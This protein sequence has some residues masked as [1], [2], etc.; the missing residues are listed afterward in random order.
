MS[1][2]DIDKL[3]LYLD[4]GYN[5]LLEGDAGVGKTQVITEI[6]DEKFANWKYFSAATMDPWVDFIGVPKEMKDTDGN[7]Y[8][9]LVRPKDFA[10]DNVEAIF[11]DE[12]NRSPKAVRNAIMELIQFKRINGK[13]FKNL[14]VVWAAVN[15]S[16]SGDY[17]V[18]ELCRAQKDRFQIQIKIPYRPDKEYFS[19]HHSQQGERICDWWHGIG[20]KMQKTISPRRLEYALDVLNKGGDL[21]D[22]LGADANCKELKKVLKNGNQWEEI[23][24]ILKNRDVEAAKKIMKNDV[25]VQ[26]CGEDILKK[27]LFLHFFGRYMP[28]EY[29][30][31]YCN[32]DTSNR[33][34]KITDIAQYYNTYDNFK[35]TIDTIT[36]DES[37]LEHAIEAKI[38][39]T[40]PFSISDMKGDTLVNTDKEVADLDFSGEEY[41][42]IQEILS[43]D[44]T[45]ENYLEKISENMHGLTSNE[46]STNEVLTFLESFFKKSRKVSDYQL[47][48]VGILNYIRGHNHFDMSSRKAYYQKLF[49]SFP[50]LYKIL[51]DKELLRYLS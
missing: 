4:H 28:E 30:L 14:K 16:D 27:T 34:S 23:K 47:H 1:L 11:I 46:A 43:K 2:Y 19:K 8:L 18:E 12:L 39:S 36:K 15:P 45:F 13:T 33:N 22:V 41:Y 26:E 35:T 48:I 20:E 44:G 6:F 40:E 7:D 3:G 50:Y 17:D 51:K 5:V 32:S 24:A 31:S 42:S 21:K 9:G 38:A 37:L 10:D 49:S 29:I 25:V